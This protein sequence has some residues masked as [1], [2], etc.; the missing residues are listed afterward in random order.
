MCFIE[1]GIIDEFTFFILIGYLSGSV[2]YGYVLPKVCKH[3][4]IRE[5]SDDGNPGT[6]NAFKYAGVPIGIMA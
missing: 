3:I 4:D 1:G 6:A 2:M 5:L